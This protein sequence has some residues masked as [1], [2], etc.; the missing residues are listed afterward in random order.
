MN[1]L[2]KPSI[3]VLMVLLLFIGCR[4]ERGGSGGGAASDPEPPVIASQVSLDTSVIPVFE[5]TTIPEPTVVPE[6]AT[7]VLL[8]SGLI[9]LAGYARKRFKK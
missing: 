8:G 7:M 1:N 2:V 5:I 3:M 6:P 9:G 4:E